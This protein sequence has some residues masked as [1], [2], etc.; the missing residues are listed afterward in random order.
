MAQTLGPCWRAKRWAKLSGSALMMKLIWPWRYSV[1]ALWRWRA[2][3]LKPRL[4]NTRPM[5]CGSGAANSMNSK[6]SVPMGLSQPAPTGVAAGCVHA[7]SGN[8]LMCASTVRPDGMS[9]QPSDGGWLEETGEN[10][11]I[12]WHDRQHRHL[13]GARDRK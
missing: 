11:Y 12:A 10:P 9:F 13:P 5:A 6:P 1:T 2:T 7:A 4:T 3:G 8:P